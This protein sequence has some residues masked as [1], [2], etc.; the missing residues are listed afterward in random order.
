MNKPMEYQAVLLK[1]G[2]TTYEST[3]LIAAD[4]AEAIKKAK[5]WT[6]SFDFVAE[7]AWLQISLN[8][9]GIRSLRPGEF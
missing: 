9:I 5:D 1:D 4:N 2:D 7:D 6:A 8:G 3:G